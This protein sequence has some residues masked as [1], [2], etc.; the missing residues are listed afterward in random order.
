MIA[1]LSAPSN[2]GLRPPE[3]GSAP[4]ASKAPEALRDPTL[5]AAD[6]D[7]VVTTLGPAIPSV[8]VPSGSA[9]A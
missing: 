9:T 6:H 7:R 5:V 3:P 2:L 4:G 1:I 8:L